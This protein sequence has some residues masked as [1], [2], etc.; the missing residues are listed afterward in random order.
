LNTSYRLQYK[1]TA[2]CLL[3]LLVAICLAGCGRFY[4]NSPARVMLLPSPEMAAST[5]AWTAAPELTY[6]PAARPPNAT[7]PPAKTSANT[8]PAGITATVAPTSMPTSTLTPA[9]LSG[10]RFAV[11]GDFGLD[12]P[13]LQQVAD[14]IKSWKP[15]FIITTGD[16]NYPSGSAETI[17]NNIGKYFHDFI[18]SYKGKFGSGASQNRFFPTLGNHDWLTAGAQPYLDYFSLPGNERYYSF[19]WG[20]VDFF[21]VDSDEHEPDGVGRSSAQAAWLKAGLAASQAPWR[22][23]YFHHAPYSSGITHGSTDWMRW[24]FQA[25]GASAV[26]SGHEHNYERLLVDGIPYFVNGVGG[27]SRYDFGPPLPESQV[28]YNSGFG[29]MLVEATPETIK[30]QFINVK[31]DV[32]DRTTLKSP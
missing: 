23:V 18:A 3:V 17:D 12:G 32:I 21:A 8:P 7:L 5:L 19:T 31:G 28:R 24:P 15:D 30:F 6:I 1:T 4:R 27:A 13:G 20:S 25:W 14:L 29:A 22:I 26:L 16:D 9:P 10:A 2:R 11:I